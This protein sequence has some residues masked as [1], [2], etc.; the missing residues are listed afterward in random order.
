MGYRFFDDEFDR[1]G[2]YFHFG[3]TVEKLR[4][5]SYFFRS[6]GGNYFHFGVTV[7]FSSM[8]FPSLPRKRMSTNPPKLPNSLSENVPNSI[9]TSEKVFEGFLGEKGLFLVKSRADL[10]KNPSLPRKKSE[11]SIS[12]SFPDETSTGG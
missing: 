7:E 4:I 3:V 1:S 5:A 9:G 10:R 12:P 8:G 11:E 6:Y 2:I